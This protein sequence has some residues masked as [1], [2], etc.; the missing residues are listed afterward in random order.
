[1]VIAIFATI[2]MVLLDGLGA[3]STAEKGADL[4]SQFK[5]NSSTEYQILQQNAESG[6]AVA[7]NYTLELSTWKENKSEAHANCNDKW[8]GWKAKYK[9]K[10]KEEWNE[11]NPMPKQTADGQ[12]KIDEYQSIKSDKQ[13]FLD[14][15]LFMIL[16]SLLSLMTLLMQY[17]TIAKIY[18]DYN[19]IEES[20]TFERIEFIN[21]TIQEHETI[22]AEH[23][24]EVAEM[25]ADSTR[26]KKHQDK[27]FQ[28]VGEAIA[29]T[30]KKK[31]VETRG[32]TVMRIANNVYVPA[33]ESK[34][35]FVSNPFGEAKDFT[36]LE[37]L[38][39]YLNKVSPSGVYLRET[40]RNPTGVKGRMSLNYSIDEAMEYLSKPHY[41]EEIFSIDKTFL[42]VAK[43]RAEQPLNEAVTTD[44]PKTAPNNQGNSEP[45]NESVKRSRY[46]GVETHE[47]LNEAV[48]ES[49]TTDRIKTISHA[50]FTEREYKLVKLLWANGDIKRGKALTPRDT[51]LEQI[52]NNKTNTM[53]LR[54]VYKLLIKYGYAYR[55]IGYFANAELLTED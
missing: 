54:D 5:T 46:N 12:I 34:A 16:F 43:A 31:M 9:A 51:V 14:E 2:F 7:S 8:A 52:G 55:H 13:S 19:D 37:K 27:K 40:D 33:E 47:P 28:E 25:M 11:A 50:F 44:N 32:K 6:K 15:Y 20:L 1:M 18:D 53:A 21:D 17:L 41:D 39:E 42:C 22:V 36:D 38:R 30:H 29:I 10:C 3:W 48:N 35:G 26:E 45:L 49:V 24:Q 4:Y 23:E